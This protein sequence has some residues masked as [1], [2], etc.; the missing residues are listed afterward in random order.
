MKVEKVEKWIL[1]NIRD[2]LR[3]GFNFKWFL[4]SRNY[5]EN[6]SK[7]ELKNA[8]NNQVYILSRM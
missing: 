3:Y 1:E 4:E 7:E 5:L 6:Y 8:W 2:C